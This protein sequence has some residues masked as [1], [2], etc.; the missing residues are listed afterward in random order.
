MFK[1]GSP[2]TKATGLEA[3]PSIHPL[4]VHWISAE[5]VNIE[6]NLI[7]PPDINRVNNLLSLLGRNLPSQTG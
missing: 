2:E 7:H 5:G 4:Y 3:K 6:K 1:F